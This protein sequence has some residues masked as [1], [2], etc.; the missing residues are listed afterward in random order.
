[1]LNTLTNFSQFLST[2]LVSW[3]LPLVNYEPND[4]IKGLFETT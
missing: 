4:L 2:L 3:A 1:M